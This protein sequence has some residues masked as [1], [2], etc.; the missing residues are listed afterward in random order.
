MSQNIFFSLLY[1]SEYFVIFVNCSV[2]LRYFISGFQVQFSL[3]VYFSQ[4]F[5]CTDT[6]VYNIILAYDGQIL[7]PSLVSIK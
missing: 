1:F 2:G 7:I 4:C 5:C 6:R 3:S